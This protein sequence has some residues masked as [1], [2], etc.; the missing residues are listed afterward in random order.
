MVPRP[1]GEHMYI[2]R[3]LHMY[4]WRLSHKQRQRWSNWLWEGVRDTVAR[5]CPCEEAGLGPLVVHRNYSPIRPSVR[6]APF[7]ETKESKMSNGT[8]NFIV[9]VS[10]PTPDRVILLMAAGALCFSVPAIVA[11]VI[12]A[13]VTGHVSFH[14]A[15][16]VLERLIHFTAGHNIQ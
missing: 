13:A 15:I 5:P 8:D 16:L 10:W 11:F 7:A 14:D 1:T 6:H 4:K 3:S 12:W 2:Q 9:H